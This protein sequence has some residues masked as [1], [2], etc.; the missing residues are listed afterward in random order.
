MSP[1]LLFPEEF[2]PE[3]R[4]P[5]KS[6]DCYALGMVIYEVLSGQKPFTGYE[7]YTA[8][9]KI[10]QGKRPERPQGAEGRWF[11]EDIWNILERCWQRSPAHRPRVESVLHCLEVSRSWTSPQIVTDQPTTY[12]S[13]RNLDL[14]SEESTGEGRVSSPS[15]E[16]FRLLRAPLPKGDADHRTL[17]STIS[18]TRL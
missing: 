5:T 16:L 9:V 17:I 8:I 13:A 18:L 6:S 12:S 4:R 10:H 2:D 14:R 11:T 1:E 3:D 15:V 7:H